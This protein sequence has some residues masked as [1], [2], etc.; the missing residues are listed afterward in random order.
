MSWELNIT[1][2]ILTQF[3]QFKYDLKSCI[4]CMKLCFFDCTFQILQDVLCQ[5]N[6]GGATCRECTP[7]CRLPDQAWWETQWFKN[8]SFVTVWLQNVLSLALN[9]IWNS[10][11]TDD[12]QINCVCKT[13]AALFWACTYPLL[14]TFK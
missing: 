11:I 3:T 4:N 10:P 5:T 14:N 8:Y 7:E 2:I 1:E 6:L 13:L 9:F 12:L